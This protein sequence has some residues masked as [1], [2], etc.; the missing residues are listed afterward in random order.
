M[1]FS[2]AFIPSVLLQV[3]IHENFWKSMARISSI[4]VRKKAISLLMKLSDDWHHPQ[5]NQGLPPSVYQIDGLVYILASFDTI[6]E[7]SI[8]TGF[9]KVWDI[10]PST[11]NAQDPLLH[12][13]WRFAAL[14]LKDE[15]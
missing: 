6:K 3:S 8:Y 7:A 9:I 4:D 12:L 13:C 5:N 2:R 15:P 14:S 10:R 11:D 1:L